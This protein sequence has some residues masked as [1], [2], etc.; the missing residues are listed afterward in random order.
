MLG[1]WNLEGLHVRTLEGLHVRILELGR[2]TC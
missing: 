1:Y 2:V